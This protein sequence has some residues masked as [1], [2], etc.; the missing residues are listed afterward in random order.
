MKKFLTAIL[1]FVVNYCYSTDYY[2]NYIYDHDK[3]YYLSETGPKEIGTYYGDLLNNNKSIWYLQWDNAYEYYKKSPGTGYVLNNYGGITSPTSFSYTTTR[4]NNWTKN[5]DGDGD[6]KDYFFMC[7]YKSNGDMDKFYSDYGNMSY[8]F[9]SDFNASHFGIIVPTNYYHDSYAYLYEIKYKTNGI[10]NNAF[11]TDRY[12]PKARK[13]SDGTV[14]TPVSG[15]YIYIQI[16]ILSRKEMLFNA[17]SS[18]KGSLS[19]CN[20]THSYTINLP[21]A[22]SMN[23]SG[24]SAFYKVTYG[25]TNRTAIGTS[26]QSITFAGLNG[27]KSDGNVGSVVNT[28]DVY[29]YIGGSHVKIKTVNDYSVSNPNTNFLMPSYTYSSMSGSVTLGTSSGIGE[30]GVSK[31]Y[32]YTYY[33][34]YDNSNY[35]ILTPSEHYNIFGRYYA[36]GTATTYSSHQT[37]YLG[38]SKTPD[39]DV[40]IKVMGSNGCSTKSSTFG[41]LQYIRIDGKAV[42]ATQKMT[43]DGVTKTNYTTNGTYHGCQIVC[44]VLN[45]T[46]GRKGS[47]SYKWTVGGVTQTTTSNTLTLVY[48]SSVLADQEV[49]C[50]ITSGTHT[51]TYSFGKFNLAEISATIQIDATTCYN[52]K[53]HVNA[54]N[55]TGLKNYQ[56]IWQYN[57]TSVTGNNTDLGPFTS[58]VTITPIIRDPNNTSHSK[59]FASKTVTVYSNFQP[60]TISDAVC[61]HSANVL[62]P[63]T[64]ASGGVSSSYQWYYTT[65]RN[66]TSWTK[67][68]ADNSSAV[69]NKDN[70]HLYF[71]RVVTNQC[72]A[73]SGV[74]TPNGSVTY[75]VL[76]SKIK[77]TI[78]NSNAGKTLQ[79]GANNTTLTVAATKGAGSGYTYSWRRKPKNG[80]WE[81]LTATTYSITPSNLTTSYT[82]ECTVHDP[83]YDADCKAIVTT[84]INVYP[85]LIAGHSFSGITSSTTVDYGNSYTLAGTNGSGGSSNLSYYWKKRKAKTQNVFETF[86]GNSGI[87]ISVVPDYNTEYRMFTKDNITGEEKSYDEYFTV[88]VNLTPGSISGGNVNTFSNNSVALT[89]SSASGGTGTYTYKWE[90]S[91]D[92]GDSWSYM[93]TGTSYSVKGTNQTKKYRVIVT[94]EDN[95]LVVT[96]DVSVTWRPAL[97]PGNITKD[98]DVDVTYSGHEITLTAHPNGGTGDDYTYQWKKSTNG[99]DWTPIDNEIGQNCTVKGSDETIH[100][101]VEVSGDSQTK[102]SQSIS[103]TWGLALSAG[104][105]TVTPDRATYSGGSVKL[106]AG[107]PSG[108]AGTVFNYQWQ[109]KENSNWVDIQNATS[110]DYTVSNTNPSD[111]DLKKDFRVKVTGDNQVAHSAGVT[112]TWRPALQAGEIT[113]GGGHSYGAGATLV[114][115][116]TGGAGTGTYNYQW[117]EF[118]NNSWSNIINAEGE[119]F[120]VVGNQSKQ[121]RV[122]VTGDSQNKT[123]EPVLVT[124]RPEL[125]AGEITGGN[126]ATY[127]GGIVE[128]TA[129][130]QGGDENYLYQWLEST[131]NI[132]WDNITSV[133][134]YQDC[135]VSSEN[136]GDEN[137]VKYYRVV[138]TGDNQTKETQSVTVTYRPSLK[139]VAEAD[140]TITF[141]GGAITL[142]AI[143]SG[144]DGENYSYQWQV[145]DNSTWNDLQGAADGTC[146]VS[147]FNM[148]NATSSHNYRVK[149]SGDSQ[150]AYSEYVTLYW[151]PALVAG[152]IIGGGVT[153]YSGD[154]VTLTADPSGGDGE[155]YSYQWQISENNVDWYDIEGENNKTFE[156]AMVN[157]TDADV[158]MYYR[159]IVSGDNQIVESDAAEITRRPSLKVGNILGN[160]I[161]YGGDAVNLTIEPTG[162]DGTYS[163]QWYRKN[164]D[165][166]WAAVGS[167]VP[168]FSD[169][170]ENNTNETI[171]YQYK[172]VVSSDSQEK[173][174]NELQCS[175]VIPMEIDTLIYAKD[176]LCY[177]TNTPIEVVMINGTGFYDYQWQIIVNGAWQDLPDND[178]SIF[179]VKNITEAREYRCV[180]TDSL[181]P[182]RSVTTD[183]VQFDVYPDLVPGEA[184]GKY[185]TVVAD[186]VTIGGKTPSGGNGVYQYRWEKCSATDNGVFVQTDYISPTINVLPS[187]NTKYRRYDICMEQEKLAFEIQ[188]NVM[189][190]SG[191]ITVDGLKEFYYAGQ[192]LPLLQNETEASGGNVGGTASYQW[193]SKGE[194]DNA[195]APIEG[196]TSADY[197]P[198]GLTETTS[199]YR[200]IVD[201]NQELSSNI[202]AFN[203]RIPDITISNQKE[204]YCPGDAVSIEASGVEGGEYKWFDATG[205]RIASGAT[206]NM[207]SISSTTTLKLR[208][209]INT[210]ELLTEEVVELTVVEMSA[211]FFANE[212]VL[213]AGEA[214]VFVPVYDSYAQYEW[215]FGDG[216]DGSYESNPWHY[217][218]NPGTFDVKLRVTSSEGCVAETTIAG[219]ITVNEVA[220]T[221]VD[222][223]DA[224]I[225]SVYPNPADNY[226]VI[227]AAGESTVIIINDLGAVMSKTTVFETGRIDISAYPEGNYTVIVVDG[228]GNEHYEKVIKY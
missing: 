192:Q 78:S 59:T 157:D 151:R 223:S 170:Y 126:V 185:Y 101:L 190:L 122:V 26:S 93:T 38:G 217:Y 56:V 131:D 218:N 68:V 150:V 184:L 3:I 102:E 165:T 19:G 61:D 214:T 228:N 81:N 142:S 119:S 79:Y 167:N 121:Y 172:V 182:T 120:S 174:S 196:A 14:G 16:F 191:S 178:S 201:G 13:K 8:S 21:N 32:T 92:N 12:I 199:F 186:P 212:T 226:L 58:N 215:D 72:G 193:Y 169:S 107:N 216:A 39:Y 147:N 115:H 128:L 198:V 129:N 117:Q 30:Y 28:F 177:G 64:A 112:I 10:V 221:D 85:Q 27:V 118:T 124:W 53:V 6:D 134:D 140:P 227:E 11:W 88:N 156:D 98:P 90:Q 23:L 155:H 127:S 17:I 65:N 97:D 114:A 143:P 171:S 4:I 34:S 109:I 133:G 35:S 47:Y 40:Y 46:G 55:I 80:S 148:G 189:L 225:V 211:L 222:D 71:K 77:A 166:D 208:S 22:K 139:V 164:A 100:Y 181:Y 162:G 76:K 187:C 137:L 141:S 154:N 73:P 15:D 95:H 152:D 110:K 103:I 82:Y 197:Q 84:D 213:D 175:W 60:G 160:Y 20:A 106:T 57:G 94:D 113:G 63:S 62:M 194:S 67:W 195:Y 206:L 75:S 224:D 132:N 135:A 42:T 29:A 149:V 179:I 74:N 49:K 96:T 37:L 204:N 24:N 200:A 45:P 168:S 125:Q 86:S 25:S 220:F 2:I 180:I 210:D 83:Y 104:N 18:S 43:L 207:K 183:I 188:V 146:V 136:S 9:P 145:E 52:S 163:Y 144:G 161:V 31:P 70:N 203:I 54:S 91:V 1:L 176:M 99:I 66:M 41:G 153:T 173:E 36:S 33:Y 50:T 48:G 209:Y 205:I 202:I 159:V 158:T 87:S 130:P 138:V 108:Q 89:V 5:Y 116:P 105:I 7:N 219:C 123:S 44:Q 111:S 69:A 51:K